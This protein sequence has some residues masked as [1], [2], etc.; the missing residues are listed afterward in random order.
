MVKTFGIHSSLSL[1]SSPNQESVLR[2]WHIHIWLCQVLVFGKNQTE[3]SIFHK[4]RSLMKNSLKSWSKRRH[5][6]KKLY[7]VEFFK[8]VSG[9]LWKLCAAV[10]VI[11]VQLMQLMSIFPCYPALILQ[12]FLKFCN[13]RVCSC[14]T[15]GLNCLFKGKLCLF[16]TI[17]DLNHIILDPGDLLSE[18]F[19]L[20]QIFKEESFF[21]KKLHLN[22]NWSNFVQSSRVSIILWKK[23]WYCR[24]V[25]LSPDTLV[26][27]EIYV[28][29]FML[30]V[31][32]WGIWYLNTKSIQLISIF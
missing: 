4:H 23:I 31:F 28:N 8:I 25:F 14:T 19:K 30:I 18:I 32:L 9:R 21:E 29:Q 12:R 2:G 6:L 13:S 20:M 26:L 3:D 1:K 17:L 22:K 10:V 27:C 7:R 16:C 5:I 11:W 15:I 24:K